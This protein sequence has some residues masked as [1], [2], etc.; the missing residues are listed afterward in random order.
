M[1]VLEVANDSN[2]LEVQIR[3]LALGDLIFLMLNKK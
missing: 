1:L 3:I 2:L